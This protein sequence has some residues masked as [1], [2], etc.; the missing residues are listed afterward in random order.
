MPYII[1]VVLIISL[2]VLAAMRVAWTRQGSFLPKWSSSPVDQE[3]TKILRAIVGLQRFE[4]IAN[5]AVDRRKTLFFRL[6]RNQQHEATPTYDRYRQVRNC[7]PSNARVIETLVEEAVKEFEVTAFELLRAYPASNY[8][9]LDTFN[10]L[11]RDWS[12]TTKNSREKLF[13]PILCQLTT[14]VPP[15]DARVLV[16]GSGVGALAHRISQH[17]YTVDAVEFSAVMHLSAQFATRA[18]RSYSIYPYLL[19]FSH[20]RH[21]QDQ[22]EQSDLV[23]EDS[24]ANFHF[25]NFLTFDRGYYYNAIVTL[26][27]IDTAENAIDYI[28]RIGTML[29]PGGRW[30]NYGPLKWGTAPKV[31]FAM[32]ELLD[33]LRRKGWV[34]EQTFEG[35]NRYSGSSKS[36]W[37]AQYRICG[38]VARRES[39]S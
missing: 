38:W 7:I 14:L 3:R 27:F 23:L 18:Q 37:E 11:V 20:L 9:V 4:D 19:E 28:D 36:L 6:T 29:A 26:F 24:N 5:A 21:A 10:H 22:L 33:L 32:D 13:E 35:T 34:I 8:E 12:K 16:P 30:I 17:G 31:E 39:F 15:K 2:V 1:G 25:A